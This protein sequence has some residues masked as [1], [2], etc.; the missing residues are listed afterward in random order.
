MKKMCV[1]KTK[2]SIQRLGS[3]SCILVLLLISGGGAA[4][5]SKK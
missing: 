3:K 2:S 5:N 1:R 4:Q